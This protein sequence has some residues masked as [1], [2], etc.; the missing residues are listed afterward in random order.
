MFA[1]LIVITCILLGTF[2]QVF[3]KTGMNQLPRIDSFNDLFDLN[4]ILG[5]IGN[6]YVMCG[7]L[8]YLLGSFLWLAGLSTLDLS[9]M[10]P[11]YSLVIVLTAIG[12]VVFIGES[13]SLLR[14]VG[15]ILV[16]AGSILITNS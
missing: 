10:Y 8:F 6:K 3:L 12:A 13:V 14:W 7:M 1:Y 11:L 2:G 15:I 9:F 5:F 16:L 4:T